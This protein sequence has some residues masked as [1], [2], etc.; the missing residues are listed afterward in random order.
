MGVGGLGGRWASLKL[1]SAEPHSL[2]L[3]SA[4]LTLPRRVPH[5]T[6]VITG[7]AEPTPPALRAINTRDWLRVVRGGRRSEEGEDDAGEWKGREGHADEGWRV[8]G[9]QSGEGLG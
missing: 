6:A 3:C 9:E 7:R 8:G 4:T 2:H 1:H 5:N